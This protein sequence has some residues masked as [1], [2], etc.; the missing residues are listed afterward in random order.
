MGVP[1]HS[2]AAAVAA[3]AERQDRPRAARAA[4]AAP[5]W[6]LVAGVG[7][8]T[9]WLG[10]HNGGFHAG[11]TATAALAACVAALLWITCAPAPLGG[12]SAWG[13]AALAG[14]GGF[15]AW[16]LA[17]GAW[18]DAIARAY[19]EYDRALLYLL[20]FGLFACCAGGALNARRLLRLILLAC[21][22]LALAGLATRLWPDAL[23]PKHTAIAER[24]WW[25]TGYWNAQG[26]V[27]GIGVICA[28]HVSSD[29][30]EPPAL[31]VVSAALVPPLLASLFLTLSRGSIAATA[32]GLLAL[33]V[34]GR[35]RGLPAAL[36]SV[37]GVGVLAVLAAD[38][39]P[40]LVTDYDPRSA[41]ANEQGR[42]LAGRLGLLMVAA[43]LLRAVGLLADRRLARLEIAPWSRGR[44]A[45]LIGAAAAALAVGGIAA[46]APERIGDQVTEFVEGG[47]IEHDRER[48][49]Q[50][51][52][53]G[54]IEH[55]E[56]AVDQWRSARLVGTGAGTYVDWWARQRPYEASA[57]DGHSLYVEVLAELGLVGLALLAV[58]LLVP[59]A[60]ACWRRREQRVL[61]SAV[62]AVTATWLVHAGIDW[63]WEQP[64]LT[65]PIVALLG[66]ACARAVPRAWELGAGRARTLRLVGGLAI[67]LL[68]FAPLQI[69][70]SQR[71]LDASLDAFRAGDCATAIDRALASVEVLGSRPEPFELLGYCDVRTGRPELAVRQLEA[72]VRRDPASWELHY[73][74]ALVRAAAGLDPRPHLRAAL[75]ANPLDPLVRGA[76][77]RMRSTR[78]R[79]WQREAGRSQLVIPTND[80][81][82][83]PAA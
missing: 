48:L 38:A 27:A 54:R 5:G 14:L 1:T 12:I 78:P 50:L 44:K 43:A 16:T 45:L 29:L 62:V 32:I 75:A 20:V 28:L 22:T 81:Q 80:G 3:P 74:L 18:S 7:A 24:L 79:V 56:V 15:S 76:A 30:D 39:A 72:A 63:D 40:A 31:R 57:R 2:D 13:V 55:W 59:F 69:A 17:S 10:F 36:V 33:L 77:E 34:L 71:H 23:D 49:T 25:P 35:A 4:A 26:L 37:A 46:G 41:A 47:T 6:L 11:P 66:C 21:G 19:L 51:A 58:A 53:N 70:R 61:W 8:L 64:V 42:E 83:G 52:A 73:G 9:I 68:A 67:L 60:A 65:V 82:Q